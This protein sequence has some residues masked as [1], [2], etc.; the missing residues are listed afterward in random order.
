MAATGEGDEHNSSSWINWWRGK[1]ES[2]YFA[3][4]YCFLSGRKV[5]NA[6]FWC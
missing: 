6:R 5:R 2:F 3:R 4:W 1:V